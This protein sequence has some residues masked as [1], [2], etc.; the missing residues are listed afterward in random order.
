MKSHLHR[1]ALHGDQPNQSLITGRC[2][3]LSQ[4]GIRLL[5]HARLNEGHTQRHL[6][7]W[8]RRIVRGEQGSR[9]PKQV[10][11]R[12]DIKTVKC[13]ASSHAK[14]RCRRMGKGAS[15]FVDGS[16]LGAEL[17]GP[18]KVMTDNLVV[19]CEP[20]TD[21]AFQPAG[22][23]LM[24]LGPMLLRKRSIGGVADEVMTEAECLPT[25]KASLRGADQLLAQQRHEPLTD[26]RLGGFG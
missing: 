6:E 19:F 1:G 2:R 5:N 18:L 7:A 8:Q 14:P 11:C 23:P 17:I 15:R 3:R 25:G 4:H 16:K 21:P 24:Q 20:I 12:R 26:R 9:P 10:A 13:P 22:K